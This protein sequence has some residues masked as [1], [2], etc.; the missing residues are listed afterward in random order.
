M[1]DAV[2]CAACLNCLGAAHMLAAPAS[3]VRLAVPRV[4]SSGLGAVHRLAAPAP[5]V[6]DAEPR[7]ASSRLGTARLLA[8]FAPAMRDAVGRAAT[9][10][11]LDAVH[12]QVRKEHVRRDTRPARVASLH[13]GCTVRQ[14][15]CMHGGGVKE[16]RVKTKAEFNVQGETSR[17]M[18]PFAWIWPP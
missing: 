1:R 3:A 8:P 11:P 13:S 2:R 17:S 6:R 12:R 9:L 4:A 5:A 18:E 16:S 10:S 7:I 15:Q 14:R